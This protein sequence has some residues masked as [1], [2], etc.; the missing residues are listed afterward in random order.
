MSDTAAVTNGKVENQAIT[1]TNVKATGT[2]ALGK[3]A[4]LQILVAQMQYQDPLQPS[5]DTEWIAQLAQFSSLESMQNMSNTLDN[6]QAFSMVGKTV[7]VKTDTGVKEGV[8][9]YVTMSNNKAY[10]NIDGGS[11]KAS[12]VIAVLGEDYLA[13]VYGPQVEAVTVTYDHDNPKA[14]TFKVD[15]GS[16]SYAATG[17][18]VALD[19]K[20]IDSNYLSY[21]E[22]KGILTVEP[23]AF[24]GLA[25]GG[26]YDISFIFDNPAETVVTGTV[27]VKVKGTQ[28]EISDKEDTQDE[29]ADNTADNTDSAIKSTDG[30]TDNVDSTIKPTN[31]LTDSTDSAIKSTDGV[32]DNKDN[33]IK[34]TDQTK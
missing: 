6:S 9:E 27:T 11:Y 30:V 15:L 1:T 26:S 22:K 3:D 16:K 13:K 34:A 2:S 12:D 29:T 31:G 24:A 23:G 18:Y 19:G 25:S 17:M 33:P 8:V 32:A 7:N 20:L 5:S 14:Q 10:V 28:P 4:F 21:D